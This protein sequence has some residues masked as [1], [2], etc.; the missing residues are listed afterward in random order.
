MRSSIK[1]AGSLTADTQ[2]LTAEAVRRGTADRLHRRDI[3][4]ISNDWLQLRADGEMSIW[5]DREVESCIPDVL[6]DVPK[7][8]QH[9]AA[10]SYGKSN[11]RSK[12]IGSDWLLQPPSTK[13]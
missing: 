11:W 10:P 3:S 12:S 4:V 6:G 13:H 9:F 1:T 8:A 2:R 7:G 5:L